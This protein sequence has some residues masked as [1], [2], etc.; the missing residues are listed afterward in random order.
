MKKTTSA[1]LLISVIALSFT[2]WLIINQMENQAHRE[3]IGV[4]IADFE[5]T[6]SWGPGPV[7]KCGGE[8]STLLSITQEPR[9]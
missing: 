1:I 5:W 8:V 4:E 2:T 6:T 3:V 9:T 7:G